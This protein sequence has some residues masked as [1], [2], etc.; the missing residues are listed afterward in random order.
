MQR[1]ASEAKELCGLVLS[2]G[3]T[4]RGFNQKISEEVPDTEQTFFLFVF[5][6]ELDL[7]ILGMKS[8]NG[9]ILHSTPRGSC[10]LFPPPRTRGEEEQRATNIRQTMDKQN[11]PSAAATQTRGETFH[12]GA[13]KWVHFVPVDRT[14]EWM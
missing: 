3:I 1:H 11:H 9:G 12:L 5:F 14:G 2:E 7:R 8:E 6:L 4:L 13:T 10:V